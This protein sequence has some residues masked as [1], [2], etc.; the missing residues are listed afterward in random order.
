MRGKRWFI[1][2]AVGVAVM[3]LGAMTASAATSTTK[4]VTSGNMQ[5]WF[6]YQDRPSDEGINNTLGTFVVG[7]GVAPLGQGSARVSTAL[8]SRPNLATYQFSGTKLADITTLKFSTYNPSAGNGGSPNRSGYLQ[9]N[10]DFNGTDT[11]QRR[12]VYIPSNNGTV[13]QNQWQEW[14]T[15]NGGM[16]L[17][18]YSGG[19]WPVTGGSGL[20]TWNQI[21]ADYPLVRIRVTDSFLGIRVGEPYADGYT[22]NIDAFKFGTASATT[23]F[24]FEPTIGPPTSKDQCKDGSWQTFN[25]PRQFRNQGDCIQYV[26]T[27]K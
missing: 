25:T 12:L 15:I 11:W 8:D 1:T 22:E 7:P 24:D 5:G 21:L 10:V 16:G 18:G 6:F 4:I 23:V 9:F 14:D 2:M 27:G 19:V 3:S 26:N 13:V 20:K 17:W